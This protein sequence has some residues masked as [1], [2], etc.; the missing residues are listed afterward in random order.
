MAKRSNKE[1][2]KEKKPWEYVGE[3]IW[4]FGTIESYINEI[5]L[6]LF[7]LERVRFIFIGLIDTRKKIALI[8]EGFKEQGTLAAHDALLKAI[9]DMST[10]RNVIAHSSFHIAQGGIDLDHVSHQGAYGWRKRKQDESPDTYIAFEEF[11]RFFEEQREIIEQLTKLYETT[12]PISSF[13]RE[14]VV[15]IDKIIDSSPNV[16]RFGARPSRKDD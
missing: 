13:S 14:F 12:T 10:F 11:E 16:T 7:D 4:N 6:R 2:S 9:H 1:R 5:F 15:A 3:F 8:K